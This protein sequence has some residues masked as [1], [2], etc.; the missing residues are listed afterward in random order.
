MAAP[1][2]VGARATM[3]SS[4]KGGIEMRPGIH[5]VPWVLALIGLA[6]PLVGSGFALLFIISIWLVILALVWFAGRPMLAATGASPIAFAIGLLPLLVL[7][8]WEG[9]WWLI[10]ADLAWLVV[11]FA[12]HRGGASAPPERDVRI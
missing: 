7:L 4:R 2:S 11:A 9:G 6:I 8:A 3:A 5:A 1:A 10:P 12:D